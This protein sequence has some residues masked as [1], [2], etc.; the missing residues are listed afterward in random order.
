MNVLLFAVDM[1]LGL[2]IGLI[3]IGIGIAIFT[4]WSQGIGE[5]LVAAKTVEM[6]GRN[7]EA[8]GPLTR[9]MIIGIALA[10]TTGI[11]ALIISI[12][13]LFILPGY[14]K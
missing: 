10:E 14:I 13:M 4:G 8:I 7:P 6:V 11:Y 12:L 1:G 3:A 5:S 9:T 2:G